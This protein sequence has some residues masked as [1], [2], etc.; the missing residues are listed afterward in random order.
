ML[1]GAMFGDLDRPLNAS[2]GFVGI[3]WASCRE[4]ISLLRWSQKKS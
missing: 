2:R 1:N 4:F 3:S